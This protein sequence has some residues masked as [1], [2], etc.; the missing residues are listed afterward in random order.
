MWILQAGEAQ[1][2][3]QNLTFT[4]YNLL[5]HSLCNWCT[6]R[7]IIDILSNNNISKLN[8]ILSL[9][10]Y[11]TKWF[12]KLKQR[13]ILLPKVWYTL[14]ADI[15]DFNKITE[16]LGTST[17]LKLFHISFIMSESDMKL[18]CKTTN[19]CILDNLLYC[20]HAMHFLTIL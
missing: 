11:C 2:Y 18:L 12:T 17:N 16:K 5:L 15:K 19:V 7:K 6:C 3:I 13:H 10:T 9:I 1:Y 8:N 20:F 4:H 14:Y